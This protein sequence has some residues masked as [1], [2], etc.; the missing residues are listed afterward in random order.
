MSPAKLAPSIRDEATEWF[1]LFCEGECGLQQR[2]AFNEWLR[3]SPEHVRAY[4]RICAFW[5]DAED[6]MRV[7]S[8][9]IDE[10]VAAAAREANVVPLVECVG[11]VQSDFKQQAFPVRYRWRAL[12]LGAAALLL[13]CTGIFT[14]R[15]FSLPPSYTTGPGE[16]RVVTLADGSTVELNSR[17]QIRVRYNSGSRDVDLMS[18]QALFKVTK[19]PARSFVVHSNDTQ[20]RA[21]GTE[22]DVNL[23][24]NATVVTVVEGR[25]AVSE[26]GG[27]AG[28]SPE[29]ASVE[30]SARTVPTRGASASS[31][32][33]S[34]VLVSA[35]ERVVARA[36]AVERPIAY[37]PE[38]ATAWT[39]GKLVFDSVPLAQVIEDFNRCLPRPL[40]M[41]DPELL[42][43]HISGVFLASDPRQFLDFLHDR[44][45]VVA[46]D[47]A[48][49]VLISRVR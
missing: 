21:I 33:S 26:T 25:V 27:A 14:W 46:R 13:V 48:D 15:A 4:L 36:R 43:K 32:A 3:R 24:R 45:G 31:A 39:Q 22:F 8:E 38:D 42:N 18:G 40:T 49:A 47:T 29:A 44:F 9:G 41:V 11:G 7:A 1:V 5:E 34:F 12:G 20:V 17:S 30:G 2:Q 37:K 35:G 6:L 10:I 28:A 16:R 19:D 23:R